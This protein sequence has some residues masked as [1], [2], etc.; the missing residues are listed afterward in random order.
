VGAS[1]VQE[2]IDLLQQIEDKEQTIYVWDDYGYY[3]T[4]LTVGIRDDQSEK[5]LVIEHS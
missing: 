4:N 5:P 1:T 3:G 2:L